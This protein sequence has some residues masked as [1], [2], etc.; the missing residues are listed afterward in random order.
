MGPRECFDVTTSLEGVRAAMKIMHPFD[1][2]VR[3]YGEAVF[4]SSDSH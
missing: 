2:S 4:R 1:L 3:V